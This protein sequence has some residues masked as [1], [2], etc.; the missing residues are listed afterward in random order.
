[1]DS[2]PS[3]PT[4]EDAKAAPRAEA[5]VTIKVE[6]GAPTLGVGRIV[7]DMTV[8]DAKEAPVSVARSEKIAPIQSKVKV[9]QEASSV[10]VTKNCKDENSNPQ[11]SNK[12]KKS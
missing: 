6:K 10:K 4:M 9:E 1:M 8:D 2:F 12:S 7:V 3:F 11:P 5:P